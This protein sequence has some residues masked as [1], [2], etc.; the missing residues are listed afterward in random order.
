[1]YSEQVPL[2][3]RQIQRRKLFFKWYIMSDRAKYMP[4]SRMTWG[5]NHINPLS[6]ESYSMENPDSNDWGNFQQQVDKQKRMVKT[7]SLFSIYFDEPKAC[8]E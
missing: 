1:M 6:S 2:H 8:Q 7:P 3:M 5:R 4:R